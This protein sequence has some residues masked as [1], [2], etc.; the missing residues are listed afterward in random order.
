MAKR[1]FLWKDERLVALPSGPLSAL[2]TPLLSARGKLRVLK[3]PWIPQRTDPTDE[4]IAD[5]VRR[6][7]GG[8]MLDYA[9]GPFVSGVYAGD[10]ERLAVR[11]ATAKIHALEAEHGGLIRGAVAR[12]KGPAPGGGMFS[13]R[14]GLCALP[15][16]LADGIGDV[17]MGV[18]ARRIVRSG[19]R[20]AVETAAGTIEAPQVI[21]AVPADVAAR[22][23][24]EASGGASRVLG[25][26]PYA[27]VVVVALGYARDRIA[28]P[29]GGFGFLGPR[30]ES[31]RMLGCLWH[32][33]IFP[34]RAPDG[35]V[36]LTAVV[37]GR[38]DEEITTWDD[39]RLLDHVRQEL[40]RAIG[41]QG[42]PAFVR[43]QRWRRAIPQYEIGHGRFVEAAAALERALPGLHVA[44]NLLRGVSV[45]DC[46]KNATALAREI[47][48][49][50]ATA[51][52]SATAAR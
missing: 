38:T 15:A 6:R 11:W 16:R 5:F 12:R 27:P 2:T 20:L 44:G 29:L 43:V 37:G 33:E 14:D 40:G 8:E 13:F 24:D 39:A 50:G 10:P 30:R 32:S 9:F 26:I 1:R 48:P 22:L 17:R 47:E 3:E 4:S 35:H 28:H 25:E 45:A 41:A 7:L 46:I 18:E 49:E 36:A 21:L 31:L 42:E 23:L 51:A 52:P 19:S 34:G